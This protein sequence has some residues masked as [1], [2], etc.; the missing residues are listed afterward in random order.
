VSV[1]ESRS[2]GLAEAHLVSVCAFPFMQH[3]GWVDEV[4]HELLGCSGLTQLACRQASGGSGEL[5]SA[6]TESSCTFALRRRERYTL[7]RY[8]M[9]AHCWRLLVLLAKQGHASYDLELL[10]HN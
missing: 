2:S 9:E 5:A 7:A 3:G 4:L 8:C 6:A 1:C 10:I